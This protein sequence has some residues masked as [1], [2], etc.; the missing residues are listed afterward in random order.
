[1]T[2]SLTTGAGTPR[3]G[4]ASLE[5]IRIP[6]Q[7]MICGSCVVHITRAVKPL[8]GVERV[9]VD[10]R[11]ESVTVRRD[12]AIAP[13]AVLGAAVVEA[14]YQLDLAAVERLPD[15]EAPRSFLE[16]WFHR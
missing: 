7:G 15:D 5:T 2:T 6:V 14:G 9:K 13:D 3:P 10:L 1:M 11:S 12:P 4:A 16:R 8:P